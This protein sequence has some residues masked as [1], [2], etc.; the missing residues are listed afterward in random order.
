ML[1]CTWEILSLNLVQVLHPVLR[2][3]LLLYWFESRLRFSTHCLHN[4]LILS[5][6]FMNSISSWNY[7]WR[8]LKM[9]FYFCVVCACVLACL[10]V[11][12]TYA[13]HTEAMN[14]LRV[15]DPPELKTRYKNLH[16]CTLQGFY[17]NDSVHKPVT[18]CCWGTLWISNTTLEGSIYRA[19]A[20]GKQRQAVYLVGMSTHKTGPQTTHSQPAHTQERWLL[21]TRHNFWS[22]NKSSV[23]P[24]CHS[25]R[26]GQGCHR[27]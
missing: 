3:L 21:R 4:K 8:C 17:V 12:H 27:T 2:L 22:S 23:L 13:V 9:H 25:V 16:R 20:T 24:S 1:N 19:V 11:Y 14:V 26:L 18:L 7:L 15:L 5:F 10:Y 6:I